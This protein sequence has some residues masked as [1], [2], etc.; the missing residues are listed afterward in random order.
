MR[1]RDATLGTSRSI[2]NDG[3]QCSG[4][5]SLM[6]LKEKR[7][8]WSLKLNCAITGSIAQISPHIPD[9]PFEAIVADYCEIKGNYYLVV[10]DRLYQDGLR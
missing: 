10:A 9:T 1:F 4:Q 5:E 8:M 7:P 2:S 3:T 6:I